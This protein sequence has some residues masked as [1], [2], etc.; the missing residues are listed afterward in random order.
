MRKSFFDAFAEITD[1]ATSSDHLT[2]LTGFGTNP[3]ALRARVHVPERLSERPALVVVL[4][5]CTQTAGDYDRGS[6]WS[7]LAD[8]HG[9]VLLYPQ[10][11]N[12]NNP[13]ACF[14]WFQTGDTQRDRGEALSIRQMVEAA[15]EAHGID[16]GRVFVTGLSAGGA[17]TAVMLATYP[18][19]FAAGAIIAG[20]PYGA[21]ASVQDALDAMFA[22][23]SYPARDWGDRV[24][25]ASPHRGPWPR[26]SIWHG[27]TDTIVKPLNA[28]ELIKQWTDV[29]GLPARP[30]RQMRVSGQVREVWTDATGREVIESFTVAGMGHGTPLHVGPGDDRGGVAGP[31]LLDVGI[32]SSHHI[33]AFWG[34]TEPVAAREAPRALAPARLEALNGEVIPPSAGRKAEEEHEA[35]GFGEGILKGLSSG[36]VKPEIVSTIRSAFQAAGLTAR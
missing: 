30:T 31:F 7:R 28:A 11:T 8:R 6:G 35:P 22:G 3:G 25:A 17:M 23:R 27:A 2:N 33:A 10:Q 4:H 26:L 21:A 24:R 14:N 34:L 1:G 36:G 5:G 29:H 18:E 9:F 32:S 12:R 13:K 19:V 16:R 20:L 15:I